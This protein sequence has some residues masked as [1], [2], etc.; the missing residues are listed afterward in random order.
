MWARAGLA[1][2]LVMVAVP[3]SDVSRNN[4]HRPK[5]KSLRAPKWIDYLYIGIVIFCIE[6]LLLAVFTLGPD[7]TEDVHADVKY[8]LTN[9]EKVSEVRADAPSELSHDGVGNW[10]WDNH[11]RRSHPK[12]ASKR[13]PDK[14]EV[15]MEVLDP[16]SQIS[17]RK[18]SVYLRSFALD[19]FDG[20][21]WAIYQPTKLIIETP[22]GADIQISPVN[23]TWR[24]VL[25]IHKQTI[26]QS[27]YSNGQNLLTALQNV[28][29]SDVRTIT[30]VNTDTYTLPPLADDS[31]DYTYSAT[32]Q[33]MLLDQILEFDK[34]IEIGE[35]HSVYLSRV[36]NPSLQSKL[37][38][39]V[40]DIDKELPLSVQL[41]ELRKRINEQCNYSLTIENE[42]GIN[43]LENF[44]FVERS[45]Y[46]E[47]Y[48]SAAAMLCRELGIPARIAFGW[49]G[50]KFYQNSDLF[51]FR[52]KDAHAWTEI[53]LNGYGWVIFDTTPPSE[54]AIVDSQEDEEPPELTTIRE[55]DS[56]DDYDKDTPIT[57][58]KVILIIGSL[59]LLAVL[60]LL[61]RKLFQP[62]HSDSSSVYV[63]RDPKYLQLFQKL[64]AK[65]G[66]PT[67]PSQTLMQSVEHIK[68]QDLD[69]L[70]MEEVLDEMLRY[71][72]DIV[73]RNLPEDKITEQRLSNRIK[74][75][76]KSVEK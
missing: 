51:V 55:D 17:L 70:Y 63:K 16:K 15:F 1:L 37:T 67:K 4:N 49:S 24:S 61:V 71:H 76:L 40:S 30:R 34:D 60:L 5:L 50:G 8:W 42:Q 3:F 72:Y 9:Q 26:T 36:N 56:S 54:N 33:P 53:Y 6:L 41:A 35:Q 19:Q 75:L 43:A 21:T 11:Y 64:S 58:F 10:L 29:S 23:G 57:W 12:T 68:Q 25:P 22:Q 27:Y 20:D 47:F 2:I 18:H 73:Y 39:F 45:G 65:L 38:G 52:S 7:T 44:L 59:F 62:K 32:S 46:C 31:Y 28:I 69:V 74:K 14:P 66:C 48:A 13:P